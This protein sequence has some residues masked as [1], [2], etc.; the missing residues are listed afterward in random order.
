MQELSSPNSFA[1]VHFPQRTAL[2]KK[3]RFVS[4]LINDF[5]LIS[6][7][8]MLVIWSLRIPVLVDLFFTRFAAL[9]FASVLFILTGLALLFGAKR[10]V[11]SVQD[12]QKDASLPWWNTWIPVLLATLTAIFGFINF[13]HLT[14]DGVLSLFRTSSFGGLC[15]FLS[16][17]ALI[18]PF[19]RILHRFHITQFLMFMISGLAIF[20]ILENIYQLFSGHTIEHI[21]FV[22]LPTAL[23]FAL[24]GFGILLRWSNRGFFGNFTLD[25]VGSMFALRLFM[26]H[27]LSAPLITMGILFFT[28]YMHYNMYQV[29]AIIVVCLTSTSLFLVWINVKLLYRYDLEHLLMRESLK[30]HNIDLQAEK[31]DLR[32]NMARLEQEKQQYLDKLNT[33][34][35]LQTITGELG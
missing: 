23:T 33:Q 18:P 1:D 20:I 27:L 7:V 4:F 35:T 26:V 14:H 19:T 30:A 8:F 34:N 11:M 2:I 17:L 16:G 24:F 6:S 3:L 12:T 9:P 29:L 32:K 13:L 5:I 22:P 28:Q 15:F 25:S 10:H 31:E 21:F